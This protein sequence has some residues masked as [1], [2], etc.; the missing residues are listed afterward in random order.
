MK[1][2][3]QQIRMYQPKCEQE[4]GDQEAILLAIAE[5]P[6]TILLRKNCLCHLTS[7]GFILN[8]AGTKTLMVHHNIYRSWGWTGGHADGEADLLAVAM[9]EARE[10]TGI[11]EVRPRE[12]GIVSLDV[13]PVR[14]HWKNGAY[15]NAHLHLNVT[16]L[17][18]AEESE[19]LIVREE[20][21]SGVR[22]IPV[23]ELERQVSET[24]MLPV[25]RK[26]LERAR[27]L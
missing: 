20:E 12:D 16:Y 26:L 8:P 7:S 24:E 17:L 18:T 15:V 21:N 14:A 23:N 22:W 5:Y 3:E 19:C 11:R 27:K 1:N 2:L 13:I 6:D 9:K 25:Y 10:E 4:K